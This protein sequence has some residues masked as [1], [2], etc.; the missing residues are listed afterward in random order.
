MLYTFLIE[1]FILYTDFYIIY[2]NEEISSVKNY[3][4]DEY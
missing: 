2:Q 3:I 4:F 1:F